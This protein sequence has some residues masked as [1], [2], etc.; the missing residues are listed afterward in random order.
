MSRMIFVNL[1]VA[2]LPRAMAFYEAM[3]FT[4]NPQ[5]SDEFAACMVLSEAINVMLLTHAKWATFTTRPIPPVTSSEVMLAVSV[6]SRDEV[7][8][9]AETAS[10][11][12]GIA[13]INPAQDHGFMFSRTAADLDGHVWE[14]VWMDMAAAEQAMGSA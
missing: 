5:F 2:D 3:G 1:P 10:R 14:L 7:N 6:D 4:N 9:L 11:H 12:G 13:D 8:R